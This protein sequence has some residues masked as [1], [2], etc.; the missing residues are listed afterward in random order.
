MT[1]PATGTTAGTATGKAAGKTAGPKIR[2]VGLLAVG[3]AA[4]AYRL[5]IAEARAA[6]GEG[7]GKGQVAVCGSD[8]DTLT[9]AWEA[10]DSALRQQP[11]GEMDGLWWGTSRPPFAEG[12]SY[13]F[14]S[15]TLGL[16]ENAEGGLSSGSAHSGMEALSAAWDSIAAGHARLALVIVSDALVPGL[17]TAS[18]TTCGAGAVALVLGPV[19]GA[20]AVLRDR[21][22]RSVPVLDRYR[23]DG[24]TASGDPYDP[25]LFR[26]VVYLPVMSSVARA[27]S[28]DVNEGAGQ[29]EPAGQDSAEHSETTPV[30][31]WS[32]A[33]P[34]GKL[35]SVLAKRLGAPAPLSVPV[36]TE[37][38]DTG[39]ASA[40]LGL[41][42][43]LA[44][45]GT[46]GAVGYGGG[47]A[48]AVAIQVDHPVPGADGAKDRLAASH[49]ISY[50]AAARARGVIEAMTDPVPMGLPPGGAAFVRGNPEMLGL[51]GSR[52]RTCATISTPP[53]VHP[54]CTGCGGTDLEIVPLA[55]EGSVQTYVVNQTMPPP[56][57]APLPLL[58]LDL[59]DGAR[60]MVQGTPDDASSIG[61]GDRVRLTLRRY[62]LER[63]VP[64]YGFKAL[65]ENLRENLREED[66]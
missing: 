52:C 36:Q 40:L 55:R 21:A 32:F 48:T 11:G 20:P 47:R 2:P 5:P 15:S 60:L 66:V 26:E 12:P 7:G 9:L 65:R 25:R 46:V 34:D 42:P 24:A 6:W 45:A 23:A 17:G 4:P 14:L 57:V 59:D 22:T 63:G 30:A 31:A 8:E 41:V 18:E 50:V 51:K 61:I 16:R 44:E 37:L 54:T 62:A 53:S 35:A 58:V 27:I 43:S 28:G 38:G 49:P 39:A 13:A 64:V 29:A 1:A 33:D 56:F 3:V 19:E 10:G